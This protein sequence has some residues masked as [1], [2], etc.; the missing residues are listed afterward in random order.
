MK[1]ECMRKVTKDRWCVENVVTNYRKSD[2]ASD[3]SQ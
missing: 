1:R 2:N 3:V